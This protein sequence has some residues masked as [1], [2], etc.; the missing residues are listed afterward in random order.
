MRVRRD[1]LEQ[2]GLPR[3][4]G[5]ELDHVVI[6]LHEGHHAQESHVDSPFR[7]GFRLEPHAADQEAFPFLCGEERSPCDQVS[8]DIPG[9]ELDLA[10]THNAKGAPRGLQGDGGVILQLHLGIEAAGEHAV[11]LLD[12]VA[13]DA[14]AVQA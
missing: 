12:Q 2:V 13:G 7:K 6:A 9:R 5:A 4:P 3:A 10:Q 8:Q 1:L 14:H 11:I